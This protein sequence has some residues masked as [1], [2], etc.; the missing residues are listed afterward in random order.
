MAEIRRC[1][2]LASLHLAVGTT[3]L[4][5][6]RPQRWNFGRIDRNL[7]HLVVFLRSLSYDART[8][9][10]WIRLLITVSLG[11][12]GSIQQGSVRCVLESALDEIIHSP[13]ISAPTPL[14]TTSNS[15]V[16]ENV[17]EANNRPNDSKPE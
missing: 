14:R 17:T 5:S 13:G 8:M 15:L 16:Y 7:V 9:H 11:Q 3:S 6:F 1:A 12:R 10:G 4:V 2:A